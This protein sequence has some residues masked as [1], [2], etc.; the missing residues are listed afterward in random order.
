MNVMS[1]IFFVLVYLFCYYIQIYIIW[2][3]LIH[4]NSSMSFCK[5][6]KKME[7]GSLFI[8]FK[9]RVK[10]LWMFKSN[11]SPLPFSLSASTMKQSISPCIYFALQ[12]KK[13]T[14][15]RKQVS[16]SLMPLHCPL[17]HPGTAPP[18]NYIIIFPS[19]A[20]SSLLCIEFFK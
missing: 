4:F 2:K 10:S 9:E 20:A 19:G 1:N 11:G 15:T 17:R 6:E 14:H 13:A 3:L 7:S 18:L 12:K 16:T 5:T 8:L